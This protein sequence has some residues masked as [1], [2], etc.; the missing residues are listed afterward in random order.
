MKPALE[1]QYS[2]AQLRE[3]LEEEQAKSAHFQQER[4]EA[5]ASVERMQ[6][7]LSDSNEMIYEL[8]KI[9]RKKMPKSAQD[10]L[11]QHQLCYSLLKET[12]AASLKLHDA[13]L[14]ES[15]V[16]EFSEEELIASGGG[17]CEPD[18]VIY[19]FELLRKAAKLREES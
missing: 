12:P 8:V 10:V 9:W 18:M 3:L 6:E 14:L 2:Y 13:D 11:D 7:A 16:R 4:D 19:S 15:L 17:E 5:A 1:G